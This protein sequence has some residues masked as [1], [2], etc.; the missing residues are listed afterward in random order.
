LDYGQEIFNAFKY[1]SWMTP[2]YLEI[3]S[4]KLGAIPLITE[5]MKAINLD[6]K[7]LFTGKKVYYDR[8]LLSA[9]KY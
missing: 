1:P 3:D 8:S 6:E 9:A 4:S 2:D 5:Y 7:S